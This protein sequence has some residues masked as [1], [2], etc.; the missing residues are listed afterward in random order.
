MPKTLFDKIWD[1]HV[2]ARR[3]DG[4]ALIYMDRNVVDDVRA[5]N[6]FGQL[7][8]SGRCVRRKNLT[9]A[10][11]DHS[12]RTEGRDTDDPAASAFTDATR[13]AAA[14]HD[15]RLFD[16]GDPEQGISHVVAPELGLVLPGATHACA[17]SHAPTVGALGALG[18]GCGTTELVHVLATQTMALAHPR[19]M[20]IRLEGTLRSGVSAKDAI[21]HTIAKLGIDAGRGHAVEFSGAALQAMPVEGRFTV[22]NMTTELGARTAYVAPDEATFQWLAGRAFAPA[23]EAWERALASWLGLVSDADA[24]FDQEFDIDCSLLEPQVTWGTD[25]SQVVPISGRVPDPAAQA[26]EQRAGHRRALDYMGLAPGTPIAGLPID[27]VF[28]G[29]CTNARLSDLESAAAVLRGRRVADGV[30]AVVV[31][32]STSVKRAAEARGLDRVFRDAGF[33]WHASGCSLCAGGNR[34]VAQPGE[35]YVSTSNRNFEGRQG[36]GVRTH[37][38]S[39]AMAAAAAVAGAIVDVRQLLAEN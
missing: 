36:A 25:P 39:P 6:A 26:A 14:R 27:R 3:R 13:A 8:R 31:P 35:R 5:P 12:V 29:S 17:D 15:I 30:V 23:G 38:A 37:L 21:L 9:L 32:G 18:F 11:Q 4:R 10:V 34:D 19:Q 20:R 24:A 16:L 28:I 7:E 33:A 1:A 22:C 2:V